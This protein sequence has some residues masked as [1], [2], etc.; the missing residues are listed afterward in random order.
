MP[1]CA[2]LE[3]GA[4]LGS[5]HFLHCCYQRIDQPLLPHVMRGSHVQ[6]DVW[7]YYDACPGASR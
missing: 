6:L 7:V 4:A 5:E 3:A 2:A 1:A